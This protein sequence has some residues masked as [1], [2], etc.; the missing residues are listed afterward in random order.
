MSDDSFAVI[1][2]HK[3]KMNVIMRPTRPFDIDGTLIVN[4][5]PGDDVVLI[6]D[7]IGGNKIPMRPNKAMI[8]LLKEE[9]QR[10]N[11]I[12]VWSRSGWEWARNVI[13]ALELT[14]YLTGDKGIIMEKA[15]VYFDNE[16][17]SA[18]LKDRV[19]L[20]ADTDYKVK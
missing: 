7:P 3:P 13:Q 16:D 9:S 15:I 5:K 17:V 6:E 12:L 4:P 18:W 8:R 2:Y 10:G 14:E 11:Y 1:K 19:Y 20:D